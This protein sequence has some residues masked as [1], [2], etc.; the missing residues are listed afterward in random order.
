MNET[1]VTENQVAVDLSLKVIPV[2]NENVRIILGDTLLPEDD[3]EGIVDDNS[4]YIYTLVEISKSN[5]DKI[6]KLTLQDVNT[7]NEQGSKLNVQIQDVQTGAAITG[8]TVVLKGFDA[9]KE[10]AQGSG[11]D[12]SVEIDYLGISI[13]V[14]FLTDEE[15]EIIQGIQEHR[16]KIVISYEGIADSAIIENVKVV[17]STTEPEHNCTTDGHEYKDEVCKYCGEKEPNIIGTIPSTKS[18]ISTKINLR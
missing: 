12:L 8:A 9:E 13:D 6:D 18:R 1:T 7:A 16:A 15:E 11:S 10:P 14:D 4:G 3:T 17:T 5:E 2:D